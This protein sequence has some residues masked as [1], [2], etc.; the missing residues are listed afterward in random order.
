MKSISLYCCALLLATFMPHNAGA[1]LY[2]NSLNDSSPIETY[3]ASESLPLAGLFLEQPA[4]ISYYPKVASVHFITNETGNTFDYNPCFGDDCPGAPPTPGSKCKKE[5]YTL[6]SCAEGTPAN[7]CPYDRN[8]FKTCNTCSA[9]YKYTECTSPLTKSSDSCGGKYKCVCDTQLYPVTSCSSPQVPDTSSGSS[10]TAGGETRY[11]GCVCP[12]NYTE[13]CTGQNQQGKGTGCIKN[14]STKYTGCECKSGYNLTCSGDGNSPQKPTD[15][16]LL[17][18]IKYYNS[19]NSCPNRCTIAAAD[20]KDGV[21]YEYEECSKKYCDIGCK[22]GY[23]DWC[24]KPETDCAKLGYIKSASQCPNGYLKCPY[25]SAAVFC[26]DEDTQVCSVSNCTKC[27]TGRTD[28]CEICASGYTLTLRK[29]TTDAQTCYIQSEPITDITDNNGSDNSGSGTSGGGGGCIATWQTWD[30][31]E[32][33]CRYKSGIEEMQNYAQC[34]IETSAG[35]A[36]CIC[37]QN[38]SKNGL[39]VP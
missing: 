21:L 2:S 6:T 11:T 17:N 13:E 23:I 20:Q 15:Y 32:E 31:C 39:R 34:L 9:E 33:F 16:C 10:C 30:D 22:T 24:V 3:Q 26:D 38:D 5:G 19:C 18:G 12:S 8:Y 25:N 36:M 14:G 1:F 27:E 37:S 4:S 35:P 29:K 28:S 7:F